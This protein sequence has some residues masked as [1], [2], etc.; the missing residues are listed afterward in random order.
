MRRT[1]GR[2]VIAPNWIGDAVMSLP[3]L[4]ALRRARPEDSLTVL[5][6]KGPA[7]I[8][9]AE[10]S[11]DRVVLRGGFFADARALAGLRPRE[12]W[13]LPNSLR[14]GLLAFLSGAP[15]RI[16]YDTDGRGG[17]LTHTQLPPPSVEHQLRDYDA[18]LDS[19]GIAPDRDPP[20]L[21]L[22]AE[23]TSRASRALEAAGIGAEKPLALLAPGAAFAWT[24]RWSPDRFGTLADRL[25][26][27]GFSAG[28]VIGPGERGLAEAV[29]AG[30]KHP[31]AVLGEDLDP[32]ELAALL[33]RAR[34]VFANDSGPM[35]LAAA[36]GTPVVAFFGPTDPGRTS[37]T[38]SRSRILDRYVFCSPCFLKDCPYNHECLREITVVDALRAADELLLS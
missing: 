3:V 11:A 7:A 1:E 16:G 5:A 18:L 17:L 36:V 15:E 12:V 27:R 38:G 9:R 22:P 28:V 20:R 24:K 32:V 35:H 25:A 19:R 4:R 10:A 8:Y 31:L 37:P 26:E 2:I 30:A 14:A 6:K 33:A 13:L 34:L 23:A 21:P 29:K